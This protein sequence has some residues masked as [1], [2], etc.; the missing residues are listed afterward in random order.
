MTK[1]VYQ[2]QNV[3]LKAFIE[4]YYCID[5]DILPADVPAMK[6]PPMGFP[7]CQFHF[8]EEVNFYQHKHFH[9]QSLLVGQLTQ[10]VMLYPQKG[11]R[12]FGINF[13]PYGMYNLLDFSPIAIQNSAIESA[14]IF[15]QQAIDEITTTLKTASI[16]IAI[17]KIERL[18][19]QYISDKSRK[20]SYYD[21][22]VD[23]MV[24]L[25]GLVQPLSLIGNNGT[26]RTLQRYFNEVIGVSPKLFCQILRHKYILSLMYANPQLSWSD[27]L[28]NGY[29][30][31]FAHFSKDFIHFTQMPPH[32]YLN[33]K[34]D[35]VEH[36]LK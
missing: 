9:N 5:F 33:I 21:A 28:L 1:T 24:A 32:K 4:D 19:A 17:E 31:D 29:Y 6:V 11:V 22:L 20:H 35:F 18:L 3:E 26:A 15:G 36:L 13:K 10:H 14:A 30:Y 25:N 16:D 8:G 27:L 23:E 12:M 7:V 2:V 34:N